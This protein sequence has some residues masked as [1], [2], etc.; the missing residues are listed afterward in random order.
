MMDTVDVYADILFLI[1][2][3]MDALCLLMTAR[4]LH[5]SI[6]TWRLV[7]A[8]ALGGIYGVA[9]LFW[10]VPP[11]FSFGVDVVLCVLMCL[12]ALGRERLWLVSGLYLLTS[13]VMGGVMTALYH[14]LNRAGVGDM[15]PHGD[16]GVTSIAFVL[17]ASVG[18]VLTLVWGRVFRKA[19]SHRAREMLVRLCMGEQ[20][21][22][23]T[24]MVDSGNLLEDPLSGTPVIV[25]RQETAFPLLS[26][27]LRDFL[28]AHSENPLLPEDLPER[29]RMRL[30]PTKT[31]MGQGFL[32]GI[33]LDEVILNFPG[34]RHPRSVK[35]LVCLVDLE[36]AP[37]DALIPSS[38]LI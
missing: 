10:E 16:E 11:I 15:L 26:P 33:R 18:W 21:A 28:R 30:I 12:V 4:C 5:R 38:L 27:A 6:I 35:A 20:V 14:W 23:L 2:L 29:H 34:G 8:A 17:L 9:V 36:N 1:N 37:V 13:M 32:W 7:S 22:S 24:G 25:L 19:E 3:G 31:A